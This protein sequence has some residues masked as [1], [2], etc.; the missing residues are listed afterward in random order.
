VRKKLFD[1]N[2][3][4]IF[5]LLRAPSS[6]DS[7]IVYPGKISNIAR[8]ISG[9]NNSDKSSKKKKNLNSA[10]FDIDGTIHIILYASRKIS[11][12]EVLYYDYNAGGYDAYPT[13]YFI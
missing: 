6:S 7:L 10:R 2:N 5:D 1:T 12:G 8:F 13:D 3:D 11:K 4:S 9:I